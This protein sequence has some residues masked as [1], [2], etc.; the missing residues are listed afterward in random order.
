MAGK[1]MNMETR[2][3]S[4]E[5]EGVSGKTRPLSIHK[6]ATEANNYVFDVNSGEILR[7]DPVVW[8][9]IEDFH[10]GEEE[11]IAK[12]TPQFTT[13]Q[14]STAY[15]NIVRARAEQGLLVEYHP[16]VEMN[17]SRLTIF[18][19]ITSDRRSLSLEVTEKCN[20]RCTYCPRNLSDSRVV[21]QG[22]RGMS[23]ATARAAIDDFLQH[24]RIPGPTVG[25]SCPPSPSDLPKSSDNE[26]KVTM[27]FDGGEPLLNFPLIKRCTEY[28]LEKAK[29]KIDFTMTTNGYL[30]KGEITDFLA[31]HDFTLFV[32]LD[33][34][35]SIHDRHRRT[36][37]GLPTHA[38]VLDNLKT[39]IRKCPRPGSY[40]ICATVACD[41]DVRDVYAYFSRASWMPSDANLMVRFAS[42]PYPGYYKSDPG[43][44]GSRGRQE[45]Y[46]KYK[47][48]LI[49]GR[50]IAGTEDMETRLRRI[51]ADGPFRRLHR[52]RWKVAKA[53]RHSASCWV[54][55]PCTPGGLKTY[56]T[57]TGDY[58]A[59][60]KVSRTEACR[61][62]SVATGI[63]QEKAYRLLKE[64]VEATAESCE[65]C[66]CLP[67]CDLGCYGSVAARGKDGYT[68]A[69]RQQAC[70]DIQKVMHQRIVDYCRV[71]EQNPHAFDYLESKENETG[72]IRGQRRKNM[73]VTDCL[74]NQEQEMDSEGGKW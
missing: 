42:P 41:T 32:D 14:I 62:G 44:E 36:R 4:Q 49:K 70:E 11:L 60:P 55:R 6:F 40:A 71:Q 22:T 24:C 3:Q 23:W 33:G 9:I 54:G 1:M 51:N 45:A 37:D 5:V 27:S 17:L 29:I 50:V 53:R 15:H 65:R 26:D 20:F 34:P 52:G 12:Y 21:Y 16:H 48:D 66:W 30:L 28:A 25:A 67:I 39:W 19:Q 61:I 38:V 64:F 46:E 31:D 47:E 58:Y 43:E 69:A 13:N 57:A 35:A 68:L 18:D 63:D 72:D 7:V 74:G 56:V 10:L 8:E 59:C 2:T 73:G